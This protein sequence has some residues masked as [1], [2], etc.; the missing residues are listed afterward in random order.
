MYE[1][2]APAYQIE[3]TLRTVYE[4]NNPSSTWDSVKDAV[5]YGWE[6]VSGGRR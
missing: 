4:R 3:T 1:I 5:R 2:Y 6:K